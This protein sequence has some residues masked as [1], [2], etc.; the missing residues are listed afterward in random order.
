MSTSFTLIFLLATSLR[1]SYMAQSINRHH[2]AHWFNSTCPANRICSQRGSVCFL[3]KCLCRPGLFFT[4]Y[5]GTCSSLC[6]PAD[7]Q[8]DYTV[9]PDSRIRKGNIVKQNGLTLQTCKNLCT[10]ATN[11]LS[12]DFKGD[13]GQCVTHDITSQEALSEWYPKISHG[14]THYQKTCLENPDT[15]PETCVDRQKPDGKSGVYTVPLPHT[16]NLQRVWCD[17][18]LGGGGWLVFQRRFDGVV[19]FFRNWT[20]YEKGFGD[21]RGDYWLG[22][23]KLHKITTWRPHRLRIDLEDYSQRMSYAEYASFR[24][25][26]PETNY[27]ILV[28]GYLGS[29][30][31]GN[32]LIGH[33]GHRFSTYDN[34]KTPGQCA[35]KYHGA[36]W[37]HDC[38]TSAL[39]GIHNNDPGKS[40]LMGVVWSSSP[41]RYRRQRVSEMKIKPA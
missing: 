36:W 3:D 22:L 23:A 7:L 1:P 27:R 5:D 10:T 25:E 9:Y 24:V 33:N 18:D 37:Y 19:D 17:M 38:I 41:G 34:D 29:S 11:C 28:F 39:N 8:G 16:P 31:A 15:Y 40:P 30:S 14:W 26:G 13:T 35:Q 32:G 12:F 20:E 4:K 6:Y 21:I 2:T